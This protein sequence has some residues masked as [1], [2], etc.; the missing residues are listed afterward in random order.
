[1]QAQLLI[2]QGRM[3]AEDPALFRRR[4]QLTGT[5]LRT[6]CHQVKHL[7]ENCSAKMEL[8]AFMQ[9]CYLPLPLHAFRQAHQQGR[10]LI[11]LLQ[12]MSSSEVLTPSCRPELCG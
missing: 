12:Q 5:P 11:K 8:S 1:M 7:Q 4:G 3:L 10:V 9:Q 6:S 2:W